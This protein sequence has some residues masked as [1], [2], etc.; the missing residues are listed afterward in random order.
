MAKRVLL[1]FC[2]IY[3]VCGLT[4]SSLLA[5]AVPATN[6]AGRAYLVAIW[7]A[8]VAAGTFHAPQLP[9]PEWCFSF[10]ERP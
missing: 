4:V 1:W 6:L 8:M 9:I 5:W 7:P 10:K 2:V 3:L